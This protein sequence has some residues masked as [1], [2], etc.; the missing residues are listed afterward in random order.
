[1]NGRERRGI[2][3]LHTRSP[4]RTGAPAARVARYAETSHWSR[5]RGDV[6]PPGQQPPLGADCLAAGNADGLDRVMERVLKIGWLAAADAADGARLRSYAMTVGDDAHDCQH[7]VLI[8]H[9]NSS[10]KL[11]ETFMQVRGSYC[12]TRE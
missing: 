4:A 2:Q 5:F 8:E 10:I 3:T 1:V 7:S 9:L 6:P 12:V 11:S